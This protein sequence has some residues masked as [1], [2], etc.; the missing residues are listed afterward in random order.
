M[1]DTIFRLK[2]ALKVTHPFEKH[3]LKTDFRLNVS[4]VRDSEKSI[5]T[6]RKLT[7][8]FP[9]SYRRSAYVTPKSPKGWFKK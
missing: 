6:N 4:T 5:M 9:M 7:T 2:F 8:G 1:D 3:R